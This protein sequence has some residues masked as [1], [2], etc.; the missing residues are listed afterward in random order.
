MGLLKTPLHYNFLPWIW[1]MLP[2]WPTCFGFRR[3]VDD[4]FAVLKDI[5]ALQNGAANSSSDNEDSGSLVE[6][7][8]LRTSH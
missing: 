5:S 6:L 7:L 1:S 8:I 2:V 4:E 3:Q